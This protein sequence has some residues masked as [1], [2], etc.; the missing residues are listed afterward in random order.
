M[1][2]E[3]VVLVHGEP[4]AQ[5]WMQAAIEEQHPETTVHRPQWGEAIEL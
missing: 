1:D 4:E 3:T 5:G 2:P